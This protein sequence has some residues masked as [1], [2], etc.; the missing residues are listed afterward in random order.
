M[1]L[2]LIVALSVGFFAGLKITQ[3]AM[4]AVC[5]D[6]LSEQNFYD[7]RLIST[8]GFTEEDLQALSELS[9]IGSAE[10]THSVDALVSGEDGDEP[11]KLL[12]LPDEVNLPSLT[13]GRMPESTEECLADARAFDE[14][15]IGSTIR[16]SDE[17]DAVVLSQFSG[18]EFTI[19]GLVH[20]PLYLNTDRGSTGLGNGS[21]SGFLYLSE[22]N[23]L[24][25]SLYGNLSDAC[26][27]GSGLQRRI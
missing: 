13:A 10:G 23:A 24:S 17:N 3:D 26:G 8:A 2:L 21:L 20:S 22:E 25:Q 16:I 5:D 12:A 7:Y 19:T 14:E 27:K 1:A 9:F 18:K 11:F 15:D 4:T 6:Y